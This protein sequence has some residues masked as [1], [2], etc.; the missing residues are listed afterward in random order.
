M[1][2]NDMLIKRLSLSKIGDLLKDRLG[3]QA[4]DYVFPE[5]FEKAVVDIG[6]KAIVLEGQTRPYDAIVIGDALADYRLTYENS[7][8]ANVIK[9]IQFIGEITSISASSIY[10]NPAL[11]SINLPSS[12]TSLGGSAFYGC[13]GLTSIDLSN[14]M[15]I[16]SSCFAGCAG[17]NYVLLNPNA[18]VLNDAF[19]NCT[20]LLTMG[21]EG[22][23]YNIELVNN[24]ST[25]VPNIRGAKIQTVVIPDGYTNIISFYQCTNLTSIT[26]PDSVTTLGVA[27]FGMCSSLTSLVSNGATYIP[28]DCCNGCTSLRTASFPSATIVAGQTI[29]RNCTA[30]ETLQLGSV[31]HSCTIN[32]NDCFTGCTNPSTV[33]TCY[34]DETNLATNLTRIRT[35]VTRGTIIMKAAADMVYNN[36]SYSAG[37][38]VVTSTV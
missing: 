21:E 33:V 18:S 24:G 37:D 14:V 12:L 7:T 9:S 31:G 38:T 11:T 26:I 25:T 13:S 8:T 3:E 28:S 29:F 5:D 16:G 36:V 27:C 15:S 19:A 32:R 17:L 30:L 35:G 20:G 23:G 4:E 34:C 10:G 2:N 22:G 6:F 1:S